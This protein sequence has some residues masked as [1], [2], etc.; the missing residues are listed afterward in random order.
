MQ[1]RMIASITLGLLALLLAP[2]AA[3][4]S[5]VHM[6]SGLADG[7]MHPAS[8]IAHLLVASAAGF[9]AARS[10]D[11]GVPALLYFLALFAGGLLLG[12]ASLAW[13]QLEMVTPLLFAL[14]AAIIGVAIALPQWF[15]HALF[16]GSAIYLGLVH[17]LEVPAT[18]GMSGFGIGLFLSTAVL[19]KLGLMLRTV[20][21]TF[22]SHPSD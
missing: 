9:W 21:S 7:F 17:M 22:R 2:Y 19:L 13:L 1:T 20:I 11:H 8:G 12:A 10:G 3:A 14:T 16:G 18:S 6:E 4:H 5:G 15:Y